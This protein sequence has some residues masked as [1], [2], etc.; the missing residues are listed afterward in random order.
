MMYARPALASGGGIRLGLPKIREFTIEAQRIPLIPQD[1]L[2]RYPSHDNEMHTGRLLRYMFPRQFKLHNAFTSPVN[3]R[4]TTHPFKDYTLRE[5]EIEAAERLAR[6][7]SGDE[8]VR[9]KTPKRLRGAATMLVQKLQRLHA[10]CSYTEL[11]RH[12]CPVPLMSADEHAASRD[13]VDA[14]TPAAQVSAFCRAVLA[15]LLPKEFLGRGAA[16]ERNWKALMRSVDRFVHCRRYENLTLHQVYQGIQLSALAWLDPPNA[17]PS[18]GRSLTDTRKRL[19]MLQELTYYIFDSILIPLLR[20]NFYITESSAHQHR[21]FFFRHDVWKAR[22][23]PSIAALKTSMFDE[24]PNLDAQKILASRPLGCAQVRLVP[25]GP[26]VRPIMNLRRRTM[27]VRNGRPVFGRSINAIMKPVQSV[28]TLEK[29]R[30]PEQLGASLFSVGEIFPRLKAFKSR[31]AAGGTTA[32]TFYFVK[33]DVRSCFDTIP[34]REVLH[35]VKPLCSEEEYR[36]VRYGEIKVGWPR[37]KKTQGAKPKPTRR[38]LMPARS[39]HDRGSFDGMLESDL[40]TGKKRTV[41]VESAIQGR[42][43]QE[44]LLRLLQDHVKRN[45]VRIGSKYHRQKEGIPQGSVVSSLL[46]N[47]FYAKF[48]QN[49]L[50]FLEG[51]DSLLMRLIDDFL[52]IT[53]DRAKAQR[54]LRVVSDGN[55]AYG[56]Q[57]RPEKSL[58]NFDHEVDG[59]PVPRSNQDWF[60]YCGVMI[61]TRTLEITKDRDKWGDE[62]K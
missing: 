32:P 56:I 23:E 45:I 43:N 39:G 24:V 21:L 57:V 19:E 35:A 13:L 34:Q 15:R 6:S 37:A 10:R 60:P 41:F 49:E 3:S 59:A 48:E 16:G 12:Y 36:M 25:K 2:N 38:F 28:L 26:G 46:C 29:T 47:F 20:A 31:F 61:D 52:L 58:V 50:D 11:L 62:G 42:E 14:A 9:L 5:Q 33:V 22:T 55:E 51:Q 44:G 30:Q 1:A 53:T 17:S 27:T 8:N 40:A 4:E 18:A 7:R 54:F